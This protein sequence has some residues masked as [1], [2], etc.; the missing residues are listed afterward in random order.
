MDEYAGY[1]PKMT[2]DVNFAVVTLMGLFTFG[3]VI[4]LMFHLS[5]RSNFV[6]PKKEPLMDA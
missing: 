5:R 3:G 1:D 6:Y 2:N 4:F